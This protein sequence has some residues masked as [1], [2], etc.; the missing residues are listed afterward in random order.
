M[1][2]MTLLNIGLNWCS[3]ILFGLVKNVYQE[4]EWITLVSFEFFRIKGVSRYA[5]EV[6]KGGVKRCF[7]LCDLYG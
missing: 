5:L 1:L 6:E 7:V 3:W 2:K 4:E